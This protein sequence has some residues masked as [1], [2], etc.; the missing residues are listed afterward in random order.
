MEVFTFTFD[1]PPKESRSSIS[2]PREDGSFLD[3]KYE[4][5]YMKDVYEIRAITINKALSADTIVSRAIGA[6]G[7]RGLI[8]KKTLQITYENIRMTGNCF[9][10]YGR[11]HYPEV[12]LGDT[13]RFEVE[14]LLDDGSTDLRINSCSIIIKNKT[15]TVT[16]TEYSDNR[17]TKAI[18]DIKQTGGRRLKRKG[19]KK[20]RRNRRRSS[21]RN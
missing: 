20:V 9:I 2:Y 6:A 5:T 19:T 1:I 15:Y 16:P 10:S 13:V 3:V 17:I 18:C 8:S 11:I 21:K 14:G 4:K 7:P 12:S